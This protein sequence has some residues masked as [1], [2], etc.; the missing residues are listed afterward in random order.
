MGGIV[1]RLA[2][3]HIDI[4]VAALGPS[5]AVTTHNIGLHLTTSDGHVYMD[6]LLTKEEVDIICGLYT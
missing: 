6:D 5:T 4:D 3:E 2:R 1:A